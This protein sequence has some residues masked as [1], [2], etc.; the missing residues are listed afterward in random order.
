MK[1]QYLIFFSISV[2]GFHCKT[3]S[4][5]SSARNHSENVQFSTNDSQTIVRSLR[6]A[7]GKLEAVQDKL[8][9][10]VEEDLTEEQ[11]DLTIIYPA[12]DAINHALEIFFKQL[13]GNEIAG[14]D[15]LAGLLNKQDVQENIARLR[16]SSRS[17]RN[18]RN[19]ID[20][21]LDLAFQNRSGQRLERRESFDQILHLFA[22]IRSDIQG[23]IDVM[24]AFNS[25][26][27]GN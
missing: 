12:V 18:V 11:F 23:V 1:W 13:Y 22:E 16:N 15:Q 21:W 5:S 7:L 2:F 4:E 24:N 9:L 10:L 27:S 6:G 17:F 26:G 25:V 20:Y 3:S 19:K 8:D 14:D